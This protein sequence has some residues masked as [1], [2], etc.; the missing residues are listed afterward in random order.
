[1][2][3]GMLRVLNSAGFGDRVRTREPARMRCVGSRKTREFR[4]VVT[5][6]CLCCRN[7]GLARNPKIPV[8]ELTRGMYSVRCP[9]P[10]VVTK[11]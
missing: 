5:V 3:N 8:Q 10:F 11:C 6:P 4:F 9:L 2:T 1:M 7:P